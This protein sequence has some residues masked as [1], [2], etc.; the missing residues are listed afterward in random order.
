MLRSAIAQLD[1]EH[2][3]TV[4]LSH[5]STQQQ[6]VTAFWQSFWILQDSYKHR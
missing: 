5:E 2:P 4:I 3:G 1:L 6:I